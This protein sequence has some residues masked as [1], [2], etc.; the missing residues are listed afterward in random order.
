[1]EFITKVK[2]NSEWQNNA[3][4]L[5]IFVKLWFHFL[6]H[7]FSFHHVLA[8]VIKAMAKKWNQRLTNS[9][10]LIAQF[11]HSLLFLSNLDPRY[12]LQF[13]EFPYRKLDPL[14]FWVNDLEEVWFVRT[15][16]FCI[17]FA[18]N[19]TVRYCWGWGRY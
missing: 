3:I 8:F 1:M 9:R 12:K 13:V 6:G 5:S 15:I 19:A 10:S 17:S 11:C 2:N 14:T 4:R 16:L 7:R 18:I